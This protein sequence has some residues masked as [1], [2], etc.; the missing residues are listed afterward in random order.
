[1]VHDETLIQTFFS[2]ES[3]CKATILTFYKVCKFQSNI[4]TLSA[5]SHINIIIYPVSSHKST[6]EVKCIISFDKNIWRQRSNCPKRNFL[7]NIIFLTS[8]CV[9]L[10]YYILYSKQ[11]QISQTEHKILSA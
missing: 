1:M 7:P 9:T 10:K 8:P 3:M 6:L 2:F 5:Q 11:N 4:S